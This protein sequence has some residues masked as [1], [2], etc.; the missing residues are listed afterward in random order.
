MPTHP[1]RFACLLLSAFLVACG[2]SKESAESA[3]AEYELNLQKGQSSDDKVIPRPPELVRALGVGVN[4]QRAA[5]IFLQAAGKRSFGVFQR[6]LLSAQ[7]GAQKG[8]K[9]T[10]FDASDDPDTQRKQFAEAAASKPAAIILDPTD[11]ANLDA[12][13]SDAVQAG[14]LV[15]GLDKRASGCTSTVHCDPQLIG[16]TAATICIDALKRKAAE[17]ALAEPKG[18]IVQLRGTETSWWSGQIAQG[19]EQALRAQPWAVL[20]HDAPADWTAE[21]V[22]KRLQEAYRIQKQF[23]VIFAHSDLMAAAASIATSASGSRENTLIIGTDGLPGRTSG[24]DLLRNGEIDATIAHPPLVDLALK[25]I[26]RIRSDSSFAPEPAYEIAPLAVTPKNHATV[27]R[28]GSYT[29]PDL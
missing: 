1:F 19:F 12:Y 2:P 15:I 14:I 24:L 11:D 6:N 23:D 10:S 18:R 5:I 7:V 3:V 26:L 22:S 4:D 13:I 27:S 16:R 25:L 29:L 20:V 21:N 9:V 17:E 8:Y 28:Q